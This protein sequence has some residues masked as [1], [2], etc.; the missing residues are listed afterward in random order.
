MSKQDVRAQYQ[1]INRSRQS[2]HVLIY[3]ED[4]NARGNRQFWLLRTG[5]LLDAQ[6]FIQADLLRL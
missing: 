1:N 6:S 3:V 4:Y 5:Q 2:I